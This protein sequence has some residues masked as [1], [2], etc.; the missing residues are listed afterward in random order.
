LTVKLRLDDKTTYEVA[1]KTISLVPDDVNRETIKAPVTWDKHAQ[2]FQPEISSTDHFALMA[3]ESL[4]FPK[5][6]SYKV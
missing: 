3:V 5:K 6:R 2:N 4:Y 1:T